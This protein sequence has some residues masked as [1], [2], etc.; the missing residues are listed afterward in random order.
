MDMTLAEKT[1]SERMV[2]IKREGGIKHYQLNELIE[3]TRKRREQ[4]RTKMEGERF[5]S[6]LRAEDY[7]DIPLS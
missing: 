7:I 5:K 2:G 6:S 1:V 4:P 3:A